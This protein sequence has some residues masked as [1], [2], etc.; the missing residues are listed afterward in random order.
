MRPLAAWLVP[1][2]L[3]QV[4]EEHLVSDP[5][6]ERKLKF[7]LA[8]SYRRAQEGLLLAGEGGEGT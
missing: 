7:S 5:K 4:H 3:C 8:R 6:A 1:A 2:W